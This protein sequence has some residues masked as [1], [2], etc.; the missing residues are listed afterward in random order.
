MMLDLPYTRFDFLEMI[1]RYNVAVWPMQVVLLVLAGAVVACIAFRGRWS[2]PVIAG[3]LAFLWGWQ[4]IVYFLLFYF[5]LN[6]LALGFGLVSVLLLVVAVIGLRRQ[7]LF[8]EVML[9]R[10]I[11]G[12]LLVGLALAIYPVLSYQAG[13]PY[14]YMP[15]LGLPGPTT[16]F[17]VGVLAFME[18]PYPRSVLL[19]PLFWSLAGSFEAIQMGLP[20]NLTLLAAAAVAIWLLVRSVRHGLPGEAQRSLSNTGPPL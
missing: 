20:Q 11:V 1:G 6:M 10:A 5:D 15:T 19:A 17:T 14:P 12:S 9:W 16:L 2:G 4:G 18:R 8:G 3:V 13:N 7:L